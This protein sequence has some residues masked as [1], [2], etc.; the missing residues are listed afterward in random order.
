MSHSIIL[1]K[2]ASHERHVAAGPDVRGGAQRERGAAGAAA[3]GLLL[4]QA[5]GC[6]R[7]AGRG[8]Q[9]AETPSAPHAL[10]PPTRFDILS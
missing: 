10:S 4:Q 8:A 5:R 3:A 6:G 1:I 2:V 7:G 9:R